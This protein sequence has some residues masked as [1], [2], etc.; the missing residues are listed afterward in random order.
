MTFVLAEYLIV[1]FVAG[2]VIRR[3]GRVKFV[4]ERGS[5]GARN[6]LQVRADY[7]H[8]LWVRVWPLS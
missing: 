4:I 6:G 1:N 3:L 7:L 8:L 2:W 5:E